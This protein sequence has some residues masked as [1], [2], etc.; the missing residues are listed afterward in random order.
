MQH[1]DWSVGSQVALSFAKLEKYVAQSLTKSPVN[2]R[3]ITFRFD[4]D[5]PPAP[6]NKNLD[7]VLSDIPVKFGLL[8]PQLEDFALCYRVFW[9]ILIKTALFEVYQSLS[10]KY[11]P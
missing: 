7:P 8:T 9:K 3:V 4:G 11:I 2:Q 1:G 10:P 5:L 6:A